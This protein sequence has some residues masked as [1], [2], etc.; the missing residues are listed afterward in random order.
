MT[1]L[2]TFPSAED[3]V[4]QW[5]RTTTAYTL[6]SNHAYLAMPYNAPLPS[7]IMTRMGGAPIS[8]S[9]VPT[10]LVRISFSCWSEKRPTAIAISQALV[11]EIEDLGQKQPFVNSEGILEVGEVISHRFLPDAN[12]DKPR[13]V[14][15]ALFTIVALN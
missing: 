1:L 9:H 11:S 10:D 12:S 13:Y 2:H 14:I 5:L 4:M 6:A 7:I 3:L 15:D 8:K